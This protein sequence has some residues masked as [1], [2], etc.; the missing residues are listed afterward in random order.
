MRSWAKPPKAAFFENFGGKSNLKLNKYL[1][2]Y[3]K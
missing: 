3:A 2:L 1:D